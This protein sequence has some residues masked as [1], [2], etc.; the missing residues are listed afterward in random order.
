V[1]DRKMRELKILAS[2]RVF[3]AARPVETM[4][5]AVHDAIQRTFIPRL[6]VALKKAK[7]DEKR[8]RIQDLIGLYERYSDPRTPES[9]I[10]S[11]T[12]AKIIQRLVGEYN[13]RADTVDE[14]AQQVAGDFYIGDRNRMM[15]LS[16]FNEMHG[17]L[18]LNRMWASIV[19]GQAKYRLRDLHTHS[20]GLSK[21][22]WAEG[23]GL[24]PLE[25][26]QAPSSFT[27]EDIR[28]V[29]SEFEEYM[30]RVVKDEA[31]KV[32]FKRWWEVQ[33]DKGDVNL[34]W[35]VVPFVAEKTGLS[36]SVIFSKFKALRPVMAHFYTNILGYELPSAVKRKYH[37]SSVDVLTY[38][39]FRRRFAS[40]IL[41][42]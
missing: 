17:P 25:K 2:L 41:G 29:F 33:Q 3:F 9:R 27:M 10:Y 38:E 37:L 21:P 12:A 35:D 22:N 18:A 5:A 7:T 28:R 16:K 23:E 11:E 14:I 20:P 36:R 32:I 19:S 40:W 30:E 31:S 4:G 1:E 13:L 6:R 8:S 15:I 42:F 39:F 34:E 26:L 24:D